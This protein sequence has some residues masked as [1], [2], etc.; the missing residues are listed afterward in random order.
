MRRIGLAVVFAVGLV[1]A[2]LAAEAQ[3]DGEVHRIG[4]LGTR[5]PS[6]FGLGVPPKTS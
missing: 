5:T 1:L 4:Y 6:D 2:S 3:R